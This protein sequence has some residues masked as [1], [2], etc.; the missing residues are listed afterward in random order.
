MSVESENTLKKNRKRLAPILWQD[1]FNMLSKAYHPNTFYFEDVQDAAEKVGLKIQ[2]ESLRVK[3]AR[4]SAKGFLKKV[5]R[6]E[7]LIS[8]KG[9]VFFDLIRKT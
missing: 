7:Y 3:L 5:G 4:Y 1:V 2:S 8:P 9:Q 6:K